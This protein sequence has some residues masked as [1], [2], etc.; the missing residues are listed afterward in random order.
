MA[1][2]RADWS[3]ALS[4]AGLGR[5]RRSGLRMGWRLGGG[6]RARG[7][8]AGAVADG[9][10]WIVAG[11]V[12]QGGGRV[13]PTATLDPVEEI[14]RFL[15][16]V[17]TGKPPATLEEIDSM[18]RNRHDKSTCGYK[19]T[20]TAVLNA[21]GCLKHKGLPAPKSDLP[22]RTIISPDAFPVKDRAL[23]PVRST[24]AVTVKFML[25]TTS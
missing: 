18:S 15:D 23:P 12:Y 17:A 22:A 11:A 16:I 10:R 13:A 14:A 9:G 1:T 6:H 25:V 20:L 19:Q 8:V 3:R 21:N 2:G 7:L 5:A 4:P 24:S